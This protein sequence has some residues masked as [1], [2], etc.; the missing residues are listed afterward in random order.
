MNRPRRRARP[1]PRA[2]ATLRKPR[3]SGYV[4]RPDSPSRDATLASTASTIPRKASLVGALARN[5]ILAW[6]WQ[7]R[8]IALG[9]GAVGALAMPPVGFAPALFVPM[10]VAVWLIDGAAER[11]A[12]GRTRWASLRSAFGA[13]WWWGFGY[14]VAG[15]WW[16]G[17]AFL[18]DGVKF[19]WALPFGVLGLP[20]GLR[21][22]S[23]DGICL[24]AVGVARRPDA[25]SRSRLRPRRKRMA[26]LR[27]ADGLPVERAWHDARTKPASCPGR[28]NRRA[29]RPDGYHGRD[30]RRA[31]DALGLDAARLHRWAP[32]ALAGFALALLAAF[33]AYRLS[34]PSPEPVAGVKLRLLQPNIAQGPD[35]AP[36]KGAEVLGR[37]LTLSERPTPLDRTGGAD[38]TLLIWPESAFPFI[39]SR[40]PGAMA[41][42]ADFLRGGAILATGAAR[43]EEDERPGGRDHYFNSIE[44][45]DQSGLLPERYDKHHLVPFGEYMPFQSWLDRIGITQ[46]VQFPGGFDRGEGERVIR[47]PGAARRR[48]DGVLRGH[49]PQRM[50]RRPRRRGAAREMAAQSDRRRLVRD[51]GRTLSAFRRRRGFVRSNSDCPWCASPTPEFPAFSTPRAVSSSMRRSGARRRWT[52][53]FRGRSRRLGSRGGDRRPLQ[54]CFWPRLLTSLAGRHKKLISQGVDV[55]SRQ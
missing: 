16:L 37:Y 11:S 36:D 4:A 18:V 42:I 12:S 20:A 52:A 35:F 44:V 2:E 5:V 21:V 1:R 23:G 22:F 7:R 27:L 28:V 47:I 19:A 34:F 13:G 24:G 30:F 46:F 39:L 50:G 31:G 26:A 45:L 9:A 17:A 38:V 6:G 10:V 43:L 49:F 15:L 32:T 33:G 53:H 55:N 8:L 14:F 25:R 3:L 41:R 48:R 51:D 29:A 40:D 54:Y